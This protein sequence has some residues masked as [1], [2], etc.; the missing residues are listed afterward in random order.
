MSLVTT[1]INLLV[2]GSSV[3]LP[4]L[5]ALIALIGAFF[6]IKRSGY[7]QAKAEA[8]VKTYKEAYRNEVDRQAIEDD[9]TRMSDA[10][11][12]R[13]RDRYSSE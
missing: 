9:I 3:L 6:G 1:I 10:E 11:L 8:E 5:A 2:G 13:L 7:K 12:E 4:A